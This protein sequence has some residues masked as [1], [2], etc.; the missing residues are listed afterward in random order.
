M[1]FDQAGYDANIKEAYRK[2][3]NYGIYVE[4]RRLRRALLRAFPHKLNDI[5]FISSQ[6]I[7]DKIDQ[8]TKLK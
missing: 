6:R 8:L 3:E 2:G 1:E 5:T 7:R 4:K